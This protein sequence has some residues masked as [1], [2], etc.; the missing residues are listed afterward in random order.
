MRSCDPLLL[1]AATLFYKFSR[2]GILIRLEVGRLGRTSGQRL[3]RARR[4]PISSSIVI[5]HEEC[6]Y[7]KLG[8]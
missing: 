1:S 2:V 6:F 4:V 5:G 3:E 8:G 7:L